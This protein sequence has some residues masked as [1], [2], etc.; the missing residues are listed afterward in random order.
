[1]TLDLRALLPSGIAGTIAVAVSGG[2][3]GLALLLLA[4]AA[5]TE[6]VVALTVDH[7][8]RAE[9]AREAA[10][11]AAVCAARDIPHTTLVWRGDKP[12]GNRQAAARDARYA[13]MRDHCAAH[14]IGWLATGHHADDQAETLLMRLARGSGAGGL[15]GIRARRDLGAGVTLLRPL[16]GVRRS[17]LRALVDAAGLVPVDDPANRS[18]AYDRTAARALL[19]ATPWLDAARLA[20]AAAHLADAEAA[21]DWTAALAWDSRVEAG[22]VQTIDVAGLPDELR[23]R[24]VLR[25]LAHFGA[26]PRGPG[27]DRLIRLLSE[28]GTATL[29][30]VQGRGGDRWTFRRARSR[31]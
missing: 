3:D 31:G 11:V 26:A 6:R 25:A 8:L 9:S 1:M 7:G 14:G 18:P 19:E 17:A 12:A 27:I 2:P 16:L 15:S 23:R 21:L 29:G 24:L 5:L 28:G 20:D 22:D 13:L 4:H 10:M 30:G